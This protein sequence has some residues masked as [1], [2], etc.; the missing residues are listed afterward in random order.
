MSLLDQLSAL[1]ERTVVRAKREVSPWVK[2]KESTN[3]LKPQVKLSE[4]SLEL[5]KSENGYVLFRELEDSL[6]IVSPSP[7]SLAGEPN[8]TY[9]TRVGVSGRLEITKACIET[10]ST[11]LSKYIGEY[12]LE[13]VGDETLAAESGENISIKTFKLV[14]NGNSNQSTDVPT[15]N[16]ENGL[17]HNDS[18][19]SGSE[20]GV[21]D[22]QLPFEEQSD[23]LLPEDQF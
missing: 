12:Q 9:D 7:F 8:K 19:E 2:I 4:T 20:S 16:T 22:D 3:P 1:P 13:L 10:W 21:S 11:D 18:G 6:Y 5:I 15:E 23:E 17:S 14:A